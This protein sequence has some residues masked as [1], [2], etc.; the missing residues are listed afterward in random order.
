MHSATD[1]ATTS[2]SAVGS[3]GGVCLKCAIN[4][5]GRRSCCA[6]GG[7]WFKNCGNSSRF[8]HSWAEGIQ[9]C[10]GTLVGVALCAINHDGV[11]SLIIMCSRD[12]IVTFDLSITTNWW[13]ISVYIL[14]LC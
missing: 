10:R 2:P 6:R 7:A 9:A 4:K 8:D 5:G 11:V 1:A 12:N 3:G 13:I 14:C